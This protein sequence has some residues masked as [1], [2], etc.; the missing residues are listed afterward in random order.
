MGGFEKIAGMCARQAGAPVQLPAVSPGA[1]WRQ[2]A[3][4]APAGT[5][6]IGGCGA[7]SDDTGPQ[8]VVRRPAFSVT[9]C[10]SRNGWGAPMSDLAAF[11]ESVPPD[12]GHGHRDEVDRSDGLDLSSTRRKIPHGDLYIPHHQIRREHV[13]DSAESSRI[14]S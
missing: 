6:T 8:L 9:R 13:D 12:A 11:S 4:R 2:P 7:S 5:R 14:T 1:G 10:R 3:G